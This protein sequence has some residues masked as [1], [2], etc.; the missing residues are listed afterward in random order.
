MM[1]IGKKAAGM[2]NLNTKHMKPYN[3][4]KK[5]RYNF[6]DAHPIKKKAENWWGFISFTG[7]KKRLRQEIKRLI[8]KEISK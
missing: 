7:S 6:E 2:I 5:T 1:T 4:G 8:N 3:N